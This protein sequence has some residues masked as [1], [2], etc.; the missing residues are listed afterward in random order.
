MAKD[1]VLE[2]FAELLEELSAMATGPE[3]SAL[4]DSSIR[5]SVHLPQGWRDGMGWYADLGTV[6]AG[7][8]TLSVWLDRYLSS[9]GDH[10]LG[11]WYGASAQRVR[12]VAEDL[13]G[14]ALR[15]Y[16]WSKRT[17]GG[18]L[19]PRY[20]RLERQYIGSWFVDKWTPRDAYVGKYVLASPHLRPTKHALGAVVNTVRQ[21]SKAAL[22]RGLPRERELPQDQAR[23]RYW[24]LIQRLARPGQDQF[25]QKL[26]RCFDSE[27]AISGEPAVVVLDAAHIE[28]VKE[29]GTD[30]VDNGLLLR[31]D[32]HRLFDAGLITIMP[33]KVSRVLVAEQ[34]ED[35]CYGNLHGMAIAA[36]LSG[37]Q[38]RRLA[39]RF[40]RWTSY[41]LHDARPTRPPI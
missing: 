1:H 10:N 13:A 23:D 19:K 16:G 40:R 35:G 36:R 7:T 28:P 8:A 21:I 25:R 22:Q 6:E 12:E 30:V 37:G 32:L 2:W 20:G 15:T 9:A 14:N 27:C 18:L 39:D 41:G 3:K 31:A 24:D 17:R 38:R 26:L 29:L 4:F 34:L 5:L 33:A 11:V